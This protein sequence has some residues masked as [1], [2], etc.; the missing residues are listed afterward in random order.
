[1]Y[2]AEHYKAL[3]LVWCTVMFQC[4]DELGLPFHGSFLAELEAPGHF[5]PGFSNL[6]ERKLHLPRWNGEEEKEMARTHSNHWQGSVPSIWIHSGLQ[7]LIHPM[8]EGFRGGRLL[9]KKWDGDPL[10]H[11]LQLTLKWK[12]PSE[13]AKGQGRKCCEHSLCP[14][15][16]RLTWKGH[17]GPWAVQLLGCTT[18]C[19]LLPAHPPHTERK[20]I[21]GCWYIPP[22]SCSSME[23]GYSW[24]SFT[25]DKGKCELHGKQHL[26]LRYATGVS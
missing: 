13:W 10:H 22:R 24:R 25:F 2:K 14:E 9:Q 4:L 12:N 21:R 11:G 8:V 1:M 6:Q 26:G 20:K 18:P 17:R 15:Q 16:L 19:R 7:T 23:S 3:L 5:Q